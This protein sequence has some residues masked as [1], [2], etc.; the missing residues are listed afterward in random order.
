MISS[1]RVGLY[2]SVTLAILTIIT[3]GFAMTA[4][5]ISG[6]FCPADCVEYPYLD[7]LEQ[8]PGDFIWMYFAMFMIIAYM[9]FMISLH[10]FA[11]PEKKIFGLIGLCFTIL[12]AG[13]LVTAYFIQSSVVPAS[14]MNG[15]HTGIP[16]I[17]QY[18]PHG[19]F[20]ALEELG[21]ILMAFSFLFI[22]FIFPEK[23]GL[24]KWI[25]WIFIIAFIL[26]VISFVIVSIQHGIVRKD[27]FEVYIISIDWLVLI[28]NGI[29]MSIVYKKLLNNDR[30]AV[31]RTTSSM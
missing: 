10:Y 3:L 30:D 28:I 17:I 11:K 2:S 5:P 24:Q 6:A 9:V 19:I 1:E 7:T 14:L 4:V 16:L 31:D 27:R 23:V 20:I 29:L 8:F 22:A 25:K 15:E 26:S 13:I 21:H 18:N 12:S